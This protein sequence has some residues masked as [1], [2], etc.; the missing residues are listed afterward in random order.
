MATY[1]INEA[2]GYYSN[3]ELRIHLWVFFRMVNELT[4]FK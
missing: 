1:G 3:S 4:S 2:M